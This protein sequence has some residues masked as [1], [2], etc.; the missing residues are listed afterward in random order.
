MKV[1]LTQMDDAKKL[2]SD[3]SNQ[4]NLMWFGKGGVMLTQ[5]Y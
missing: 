2:A 5:L 1:N 4:T 3:H